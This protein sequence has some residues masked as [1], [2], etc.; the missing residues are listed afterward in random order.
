[1]L[2]GGYIPAGCA[3][4]IFVEFLTIIRLVYI[5]SKSDYLELVPQIRL[6]GQYHLCSGLTLYLRQ[7]RLFGGLWIIWHKKKP[8]DLEGFEVG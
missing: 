3:R 4:I 2:M 8:S 7:I 1:M 6:F 5:W